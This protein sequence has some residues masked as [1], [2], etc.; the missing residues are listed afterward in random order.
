M[1]TSWTPSIFSQTELRQSVRPNIPYD[2]TLSPYARIIL[3]M[4]LATPWKIGIK[5]LDGSPK[6]HAIPITVAVRLLATLTTRL[7]QQALMLTADI[8]CYLIQ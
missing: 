8:H 6:T 7:N 4:H 2:Q 1:K 5:H 3:L